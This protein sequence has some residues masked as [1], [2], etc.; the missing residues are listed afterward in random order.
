MFQHPDV[1]WSLTERLLFITFSSK[2][3][4]EVNKLIIL[5]IIS[6]LISIL[7]EGPTPN[8]IAA[9]F[10]LGMFLGMSPSFNLYTGIVLL[11]IFLLDVN[12]SASILGW[13]VFKLFSYAMDPV[14][15]DAGFIL[16][17]ESEWLNGFWTALYNLPLI[18]LSKYN[19]TV[20]LGSIVFSLLLF[21]P[22]FYASKF[23]TVQYRE[24][25][26]PKMRKHKIFRVLKTSKFYTVYEKITKLKE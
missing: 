6:R 26:N 25:L 20:V 7:K 18:P 23:G 9:G 17:S 21:L 16:L 12:I 4:N 13:I 1:N 2:R 5:K 15:H 19:N 22:I 8:Q 10:T 14:F 11:L 3:T 24:K